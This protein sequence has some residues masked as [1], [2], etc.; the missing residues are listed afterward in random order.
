MII[1]CFIHLVMLQGILT[2]DNAYIEAATAEKVKNNGLGM[3]NK[4][5]SALYPASGDSDDWMYDGDLATKPKIF[6]Y[7]PEIGNDSHGFWPASAD[8]E[9]VCESMVYTNLTT[10]KLSVKLRNRS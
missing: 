8:I 4:L 10:A 5:S 9:T 3:V 7:T 6:A 1:H 2:P